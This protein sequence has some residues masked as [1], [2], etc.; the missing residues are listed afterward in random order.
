MISPTLRDES[1]RM[2]HPLVSVIIPTYN[3]A[4]M[5]TRC[6]RSVLASDYPSLEVIVVDDCSP[7]RIKGT[8][9]VEF[10]TEPRFLC[11]RN[12]TNLL[13]TASRNR[14][15]AA[16]KGE[17]L[18][19]LD[20]DNE[21]DRMAISEMIA[22][23]ERHPKAGL[24]GALSIQ[25][26]TG[27]RR[28]V[29]TVG[30][31]FHRWTSK[32]NDDVNGLVPFAS[33]ESRFPLAATSATDDDLPTTYSPNAFM[34]PKKVF[35]E[36]GGFDESL[37][38]MYDESDFGWR[39]KETGYAA[40]FARRAITT[41]F[42]YVESEQSTPLRRLGIEKPLRT[43]CFARNRIRFARRHFTFL[44]ALS[45][46]FVFAPLSAGYYCL[47]ALKNRRP[48]IAWAYFKGTV[49]GIFGF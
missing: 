19:F 28:L 37:G 24:I 7:S 26:A 44:Q 38:M 3:R 29:W 23:F 15:A 2:I 22:A 6:V 1:V 48:D 8:L 32:P 11:V 33:L 18:F 12:E 4:E 42:G 47:V 36:V 49:L 40:F 43:F 30:A 14:G 10:A 41:H 34:V 35:D 31:D 39:I 9:D 5:V 27:E 16:A 21:L 25:H 45:V 17:Y 20:D 13:T 46:A